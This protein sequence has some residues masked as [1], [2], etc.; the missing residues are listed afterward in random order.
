[1]V[2]GRVMGPGGAGNKQANLNAPLACSAQPWRTITLC[3][4]NLSLSL[5]LQPIETT[6]ATWHTIEDTRAT[7]T[8]FQRMT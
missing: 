1:M 5:V 7:P 8:R 4:S 2:Y 3:A 6:T